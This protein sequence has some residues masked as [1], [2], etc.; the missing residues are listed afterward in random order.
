MNIRKLHHSIRNACKRLTLDSKK[1]ALVLRRRILII[2]PHPDDEVLGCGALIHAAISRN[3]DVKVVLMT[4]GER[5]ATNKKLTKEELIAKRRN[6][7]KKANATLGLTPPN[8]TFL[9]YKD[10]G[11]SPEDTT[12][13]ERLINLINDFKPQQVFVSSYYDTFADHIQCKQVL[14]TIRHNHHI[15]FDLYEY[16]VWFWF[17]FKVRQLPR[18]L[19]REVYALPIPH[20]AKQEAVHIYTEELD[21]TGT[22]I[23]GELPTEM[24]EALLSKNEFYLKVNGDN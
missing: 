24:I 6:L 8:I 19:M 21:E 10:G 15:A 3:R 4:G 5:L 1:Q 22:R 11:I 14:E 2:A 13:T 12:Q 18:L 7:T 9:D 20:E 16:L 23:S 17:F